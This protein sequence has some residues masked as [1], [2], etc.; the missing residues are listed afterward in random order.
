MYLTVKDLNELTERK[1]DLGDDNSIIWFSHLSMFSVATVY[2]CIIKQ[3]ACALCVNRKNESC[4][5]YIYIYIRQ[6]TV[7]I[8]Q[9][10]NQANVLWPC[11]SILCACVHICMYGECRMDISVEND[12]H[13]ASKRVLQLMPLSHPPLLLCLSAPL[14]TQTT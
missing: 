11:K 4:N 1:T 3:P 10:L 12:W 13:P 14:Y 9:G 5:A 2:D 7:L 8:S 6:H